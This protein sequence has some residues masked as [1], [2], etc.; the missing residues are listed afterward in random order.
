[1]QIKNTLGKLFQPDPHFL[2]VFLIILAIFIFG[3]QI[4]IKQGRNLEIEDLRIKYDYLCS[5]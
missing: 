1:M 3:V 5:N 4:G 2:Y